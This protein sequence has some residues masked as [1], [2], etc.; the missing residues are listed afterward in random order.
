MTDHYFD[1]HIRRLIKATNDLWREKDSICKKCHKIA[2]EMN[3][4]LCYCP[5]YYMGTECGGDFVIH[6]NGV[7]DCSHCN[8]PHDPVFAEEFLKARIKMGEG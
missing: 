7:K 5:R 8:K 3:C 6:D 2:G 4:L 1:Y